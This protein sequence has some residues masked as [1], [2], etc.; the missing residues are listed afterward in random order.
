MEE[1]N[2]TSTSR[3]DFLKKSLK[4][5]GYS[6]PAMMVFS[7]V[8]LN[9]IARKYPSNGNGPAVTKKKKKGNP[10]PPRGSRSNGRRGRR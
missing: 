2:E 3:R 4:T 9:A 7:S 1:L 5:V 8:S 10:S 6:I